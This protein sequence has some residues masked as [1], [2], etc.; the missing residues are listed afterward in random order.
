M[1]DDP[2]NRDVMVIFLNKICTLDTADSGEAALNMAASKNYDLIL[3]D[4]NLG[5]SMS[6]M[7]VVKSLLAMPEY[8]DIPIIAVTAYS[9]GNER[10]E[11]LKG[12]CTHYLA[13][14]FRKRELI[15]LVESILL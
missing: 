4:I 10:S 15:D 14:P 7:D 12:G 6:G 8:H 13:K 9:M 1:E 3:L 2:I 5:D 11:F